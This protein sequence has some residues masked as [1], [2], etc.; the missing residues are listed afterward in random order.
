MNGRPAVLE[1][2]GLTVVHGLRGQGGPF[3]RPDLFAAVSDV[4]IKVLPG[5][6][7]GLVGESGSGKSTTARAICGLV[8]YQGQILFSGTDASQLGAGAAAARHRQMVFQDPYSSLDPLMTVGELVAEPL[9]L[10]EGRSRGQAQHVHALMEAVRLPAPFASRLPSELSGG[11]RQRVAIA[12]ALATEP[13]LVICDEAL[14]ALDAST[15]GEVLGILRELRDQRGLAYLFIAHDLAVVRHLADHVAVMYLGSV[16]ES[17]PTEVIFR[18]PKHP[19]TQ[20]LLAAA[21]IPHPRLQRAR[22]TSVVRG[23]PPDP[24]R[25]PSGCPFHPRCPLALD[26][27][28]TEFPDLSSAGERTV[29]CHV[30]KAG[31]PAPPRAASLENGGGVHAEGVAL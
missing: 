11:Q 7:L 21:P 22:R 10:L 26:R 30:N 5:Q 27:C 9:T 4:N 12:R 31:D 18:D 6:T 29:F 23:E 20:A 3:R 14:S 16:V 28:K 24:S 1:T 13:A 19:Y 8:R 17:G 15:Q 25:R 2:R